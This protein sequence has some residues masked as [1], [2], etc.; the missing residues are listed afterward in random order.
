MPA[1][2]RIEMSRQVL[3]LEAVRTYYFAKAF[4]AGSRKL[5]GDIPESVIRTTRMPR[6]CL[7]LREDPAKR[8]SS[9]SR[10]GPST[11]HGVS[12]ATEAETCWTRCLPGVR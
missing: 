5:P 10:T 8:R 1:S 4:W 2:K 3:V 6:C 12:V 9:S 11:S 7:L